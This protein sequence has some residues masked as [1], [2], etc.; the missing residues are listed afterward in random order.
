VLDILLQIIWHLL[1]GLALFV[2]VCVWV[3][4]IMAIYITLTD[5]KIVK[6]DKE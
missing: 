3:G 6:K 2:L 4:A 5:H 1:A